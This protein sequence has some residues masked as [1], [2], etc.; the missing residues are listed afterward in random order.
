MVHPFNVGDKVEWVT[1]RQSGQTIEI[2]KHEGFVDE[3]QGS[4]ALI[5]SLGFK[6]RRKVSLFELKIVGRKPGVSGE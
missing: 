4:Q 1:V 2:K 3:I 5:K 6:R